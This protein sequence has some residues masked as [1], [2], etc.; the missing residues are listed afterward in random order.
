MAEGDFIFGD[1]DSRGGHLPD[2]P[3]CVIRSVY[4]T[5][6]PWGFEV[7]I[8]VGEQVSLR[9]RSNLFAGESERSFLCLRPNGE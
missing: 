4:V 5:A 8:A 7:A 9:G 1:Q 3:G 2:L 6:Q